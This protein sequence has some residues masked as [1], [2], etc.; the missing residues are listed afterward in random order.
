MGFTPK[1]HQALRTHEVPSLNK[2][3][4]QI[5]ALRWEAQKAVR[6]AQHLM[7]SKRGRNFTPYKEG[8]QVWLE[9][10]NIATTHPTSKLAPQRHRPF[11]ITKVISEVVY[12]L[13]LPERWKIHN[14]FHA[15]LLSP[16]H[17][18]AIHGPNYHNPPPDVID[19][20]PEWEVEEVMDKRRFGRK[21]ELQYRIRWKG[22]SQA[23]DSWEPAEN[24]HAPALIEEYYKRQRSKD[25]NPSMSDELLPSFI[26]TISVTNMVS[27]PDTPEGIA[28]LKEIAHES[29]NVLHALMDANRQASPTL[30]SHSTD[31]ELITEEEAAVADDLIRQA[32][33]PVI[34]PVSTT[35]HQPTPP[36]SLS[37]APR[38]P[39]PEPIVPQDPSF[40]Y[41]VNHPGYPWM[42]ERK[43]RHVVPI[44]PYGGGFDQVA[45]Y[46]MPIVSP[47]S[48][49]PVLRGTMG[50]DEPV[51]SG[52]L[53]AE[54]TE[55][56]EDGHQDDQVGG[57]PLGED[58]VFDIP[59]NRALLD[60]E[61]YGVLA[62]VWRL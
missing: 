15:S 35:T 7:V 2:R 59:I 57:Y 60:L 20:Q 46:V 34:P 30:S 21:K 53:L 10:T 12:E 31:P 22:Y 51:Y 55:G 6:H 18:T 19:G 61:D 38:S 13:K 29:L 40:L 4:A 62:D 47:T 58:T 42:S 14:V 25:K 39:T 24:I 16:Y 1:A 41:D 17:E 49:E 5:E 27:R 43:V 44:R 32:Q 48:G 8:D 56:N 9:A 33:E 36:S 28:H 26:N 23:H 37:Y 45:R 50:A 54:P 3:S 52:D 11:K